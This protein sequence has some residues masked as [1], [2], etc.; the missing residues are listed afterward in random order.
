VP[1]D[2]HFVRQPGIPFA[3]ANLERHHADPLGPVWRPVREE[4]RKRL[5][6]LGEARP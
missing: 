1:V 4:R 6:I 5:I 3:T 2:T